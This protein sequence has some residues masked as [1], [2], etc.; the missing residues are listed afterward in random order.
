[1]RSSHWRCSPQRLSLSV[2]PPHH[3][4]HEKHHPLRL[5][6]APL[7]PQSSPASLAPLGSCILRPR[8]PAAHTASRLGQGRTRAA[9]LTSLT[10]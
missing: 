9:A 6:Q 7:H 2:H 3:A 5:H 4:R 8:A 1:M 10:C